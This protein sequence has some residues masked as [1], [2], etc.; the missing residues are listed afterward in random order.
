PAAAVHLARG[1]VRG[2]ALAL[3]FHRV[4][5]VD[6]RLRL[7]AA[8]DA[9]ARNGLLVHEERAAVGAARR[10]HRTG[11]GVV[12]LMGV[13]IPVRVDQVR[14]E[15]DEETVEHADGLAVVPQIVR[16]EVQHL[17]GRAENPGPLLWLPPPLP[18]PVLDRVA[19]PAV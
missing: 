5:D 11:H 14:I 10:D 7:E 2:A 15:A 4:R 6:E 8:R 1:P 13:L 16:R 18:A 3:A 9:A 19:G 12:I 17:E